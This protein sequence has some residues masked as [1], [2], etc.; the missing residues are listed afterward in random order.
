MLPTVHLS[1][2]PDQ[3]PNEHNIWSPV[4]ITNTGILYN[5]DEEVDDTHW[6]T[7]LLEHLDLPQLQ[8]TER[9]P[10]AIEDWPMEEE[11]E[12]ALA[13]RIQELLCELLRRFPSLTSPV[14]L[15]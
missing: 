3:H 9:Q 8:P 15:R 7:S 10:K 4:T 11:D 12:Q 6:Y 13:D 2:V 1:M 14:S 5:I